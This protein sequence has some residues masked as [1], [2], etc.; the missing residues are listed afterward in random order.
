[1]PFGWLSLTSRRVS[2]S[3]REVLARSNF[4]IILHYQWG[5]RT[6]YAIC[7]S[8]SLIQGAWV[9]GQRVGLMEVNPCTMHKKCT[10]TGEEDRR[11][12]NSPNS[13]GRFSI[14]GLGPIR[15]WKSLDG[16]EKKWQEKLLP[17]KEEEAG[18]WEARES[19]SSG[20]IWRGSSIVVLVSPRDWAET[21]QTGAL[22]WAQSWLWVLWPEPC[23]KFMVKP[24]SPVW[25]YWNKELIDV[26]WHQKGGA[27]INKIQFSSVTQLH[28]TLCDPMDCSTPGF[29]VLHQLLELTQTHA[30]WVSDAIQLSHPLLSPSTPVFSLSQH[31]G[32]FQ[33]I[34][35]LHQVAKV[36]ELQLQPQSFQ[37]IFRTD[38]L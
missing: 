6:Q 15:P 26:Q 14:S 23:P 18:M 38:F 37:W 16:E 34:S 24:Y 13:S 1:M 11:E 17:S 31:Q 27:L 9:P 35:S 10:W 22:C 21:L 19:H 29:P 36:L 28:L 8:F 5:F 2:S 4:Q 3:L 33:W 12:K 20:L 30:H 25:R 32:L 7:L